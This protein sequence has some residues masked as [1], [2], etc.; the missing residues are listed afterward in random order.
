MKVIKP[1]TITPAMLVSTTA[2]E[3]Y[4][5]W[6]GSTN[7]LLNARVIVGGR[8]YECIRFDTSPIYAP[9]TNA[10]YWIDKGIGNIQAMFDDRISTAT[11][12]ATSLSIVLD[13]G[14]INSLGLFGLVGNTLTLTATNG[15]GGELVFSKSISLDGTIIADWYQYFFEPSV[16]LGEVILTDIPPYAGLRLTITVTGATTAIGQI[17]IGT[18]YELGD[19][20]LGATAGIVDYST[21]VTDKSGYSTFTPGNFSKRVNLTFMLPNAQLNKVQ[22]VLTDVRQK[23][24]AWIGVDDVTYL[25]LYLFGPYRDFSIEIPY[26]TQSLCSMEIIGIT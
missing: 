23:P 11:T 5:A 25:P 8:I 26:A 2:T 22:R 6:V 17:A 19:T 9:V 15:V 16:Q 3:L 21:V 18:F 1:V 14:I 7:Y 20:Q 4:A 10:L 12:A 24:C 13:T